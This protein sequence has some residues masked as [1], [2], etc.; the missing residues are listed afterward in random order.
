MWPNLVRSS[1][2]PETHGELIYAAEGHLHRLNGHDMRDS[3]VLL[4]F[5]SRGRWENAAMLGAAACVFIGTEDLSAGELRNKY[6]DT[7]LDM[8]RFWVDAAHG[9]RLRALCLAEA[10]K[11]AAARKPVRVTIHAR[12]DWE[13]RVTRNVYGFLAGTDPDIGRELIVLEAYYDSISVVP[14]LAPGAAQGCSLAALLALADHFAAH[15]PKRSVLFLASGGH[16]QGFAGV[17]HFFDAFDTKVADL[18]KAV[19]DTG[20]EVARLE[21]LAEALAPAEELA[22]RLRATRAAAWAMA[23]SGGLAAL[24]QSWLASV[25]ERTMFAAAFAPPKLPPGHSP[26]WRIERLAA[27]AGEL[28]RL[29]R[30]VDALEK[31]QDPTQVF[32]VVEAVEHRDAELMAVGAGATAL[33][34]VVF[35]LLRPGRGDQQ[36]TPSDAHSSNDPPVH[37]STHPRLV[38]AVLLAGFVAVAV[39]TQ[40]HKILLP[41]AAASAVAL[42]VAIVLLGHKELLGVV[43]AAALVL[44]LAYIAFAALAA[45]AG[46]FLTIVLVV[47]SALLLILPVAPFVKEPRDRLRGARNVL[48]FFTLSLI[49]LLQATAWTEPWVV[50]APSLPALV[51]VLAVLFVSREVTVA[52]CR[53][54]VMAIALSFA[55]LFLVG[56]TPTKEVAEADVLRTKLLERLRD[57]MRVRAEDCAR[58]LFRLRTAGSGD[59]K[60]VAGLDDLRLRYK[61]LSWR[62][63]FAKLDE[64]EEELFRP[65]VADARRE[66]AGR[67]AYTR[68]K[69][70]VLRGKLRLAAR[71]VHHKTEE[72]EQERDK[73]IYLFVGLELSSKTAQLGAFREGW[74]YRLP[75]LRHVTDTYSP[76]S[77]QLAA[78]ARDLETHCDFAAAAPRADAGYAALHKHERIYHDVIRGKRGRP[79]H[80]YIPC[81]GFSSEVADLTG[82]PGLTFATLND[83]RHRVDSPADT[84]EHINFANLATQTR[85]LL[86][87]IEDMADTRGL[88]R[89]VEYPNGFGRVKGRLTMEL[90][91]RRLPDQPVPNALGLLYRGW[92]QYLVGAR[93]RLPQIT[94]PDGE[95]GYVGMANHPRARWRWMRMD[96]YRLDP[97]TGRITMA[98]N[99]AMLK[100]YPNGFRNNDRDRSIRPVLF[101]CKAVALYNLF[102]QR[103]F[104]QLWGIRLLDARRESNPI[105]YGYD[106]WWINGVLYLEP[107][108]PFKFIM[109]PRLRGVRL[110][111]LNASKEHPEGVGYTIE[112]LQREPLIPLLVARDFAHLVDYRLGV[113]EARGIRNQ[114]LREL[115]EQAKS[116]LAEAEGHLKARRYDRAIDAARSAWAYE[117]RAYPDVQATIHDTVAGVLFYVALLLPFSYCIER[118]FFSFARIGARAAA[119]I[120]VMALAIAVLWQVHPAFELSNNPFIVIL[121]FFLLALGGLTLTIIVA[122]FEDEMKKLERARSGIEVADV[123]RMSA[124]GAAFS[125]GISNMRR[126]KVRTALTATTLIILTFAI[127]SFTSTRTRPVEREQAIEARPTYKGVLIRRKLW[128]RMSGLVYGTLY[129][130]YREEAIVAPRIWRGPMRKGERS[131]IDLRSLDGKRKF[132]VKSLLGLSTEEHKLLSGELLRGSPDL[133]RGKTGG[134]RAEAGAGNRQSALGTRQLLEVGRWFQRNNASEILLPRRVASALG[135]GDEDVGKAK[136]LLFGIEFIVAGIFRGESFESFLDLNG[137]PVTPVDWSVEQEAA[138][139]EQE[140]AAQEES[141]TGVDARELQYI[142]VPADEMAVLPYMTLWTLGGGLRSVAVALD[143]E[144]RVEGRGSR[145]G[146][147]DPLIRA[148]DRKQGDTRPSPPAPRHSAVLRRQSVAHMRRHLKDRLTL[149]LYFGDEEGVYKFTAA[150]V[151]SFQ[152]LRNVF[153]PLV[154]A[155]LIVLNTMLGSVHERIREVGIYSSVGLA[156]GHISMLFIAEAMGLATVS[157]VSGYLVSQTVVKVLFTMNWMDTQHMFLNYSSLSTVGSLLFVVLMVLASTAYPAHMVSRVASPGIERRWSLPPVH[158]DR[159][160]LRLPYSLTEHDV[161]GLML[162]LYNYIRAHEEI[163]LGVFC[164]RDV[165]LAT[166]DGRILL[167]FSAWLAPYDLGVYQKVV[168]SS[169][170]AEEEGFDNTTVAIDRESGEQGAWKR[171]NQTFLNQL[172]KQFLIWRAIGAAGR[173]KYVRGAAERFA[174]GR[175]PSAR[176]QGGEDEGRQEDQEDSQMA[177]DKNK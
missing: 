66:M 83:E 141:E 108:T 175:P 117:S 41:A 8:P 46:W 177:D 147:E 65:F 86:A 68:R 95:F 105:R 111:L 123:S 43:R 172:R 152:G 63:D 146:R 13:E 85:F 165:A 61:R 14:S 96:G 45:E 116:F 17:R 37:P 44:G 27:A 88:V 7:P 11:P 18:N 6:Y 158:G 133:G 129:D 125:L 151:P 163:S 59:A 76:L 115:H 137:E 78:I 124:F 90:S 118:L 130:K 73:G 92:W 145:V 29:E 112:Q 35:V 127:M 20:K 38:L 107:L 114:R 106:K 39:A 12:V 110:V 42:A 58:Q 135:V 87:M 80:T 19:A 47:P 32:G 56:M 26:A 16:A 81:M 148:L 173:E 93:R 168:I 94:G 167:T 57:P 48:L 136:V 10:K 150:D 159:I 89:L 72:L 100:K 64:R 161:P 101:D 22:G 153:V 122:R 15:P 131:Y 139:Q 157:A 138:E 155:F 176:S 23:P 69:H 53:R 24:K 67:L 104:Q 121:A 166:E 170:P 120:G 109:A 156:P 102:D 34:L 143:P 98:V 50:P 149:T 160:E 140:A 84:I 9:E 49:A 82:E 3:V 33:L 103:Y 154:I 74:L 171:N 99:F 142:H 55:L 21:R 4:D 25:F 5:N 97:E 28:A 77:E 169:A 2:I 174:E 40:S 128:A 51:V 162:F 62:E 132:T 52:S 70:D 91:G 60:R 113:L 1:T 134:R 71:L 30:I 54:V 164:V 36:H 79:W 119:T 144:K 126:R 75:A 31:T